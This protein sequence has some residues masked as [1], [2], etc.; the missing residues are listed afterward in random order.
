VP[1][2]KS[3]KADASS[4]H[5]GHRLNPDHVEDGVGLRVSKSLPTVPERPT[6]SHSEADKAA[7]RQ[8]EKS[9]ELINESI[10]ESIKIARTSNE[11]DAK[12]MELDFAQQNLERLKALLAKHP[13]IQFPSLNAIEEQITALDSA[14][15]QAGLRRLVATSPA[16]PTETPHSSIPVAPQ[17]NLVS[18]PT[19][20]KHPET[21][22][23]SGANAI[24]LGGSMMVTGCLLMILIPVGLVLLLLVLGFIL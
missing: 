3:P 5:D 2:L 11:P 13:T 19:S 12:I 14:F 7:L 22:I 21:A 20:V 6:A 15:E 1:E 9:V 10:N 8:A 16:V 4:E 18:E 23:S 24:K 17:A